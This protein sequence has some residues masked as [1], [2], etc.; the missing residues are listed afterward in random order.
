MTNSYSIFKVIGIVNLLYTI[1]NYAKEH[2][3]NSRL[4]VIQRV[5]T[6]VMRLIIQFF[7]LYLILRRLK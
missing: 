4:W 5:L 1:E 7:Y 6:S 2:G 3:L